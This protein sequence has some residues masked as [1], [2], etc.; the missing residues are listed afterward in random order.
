MNVA[1][2]FQKIWIFF[3]DDRFVSVLE[4]VTT[5]FVA[6]IKGDSVPSHETAHHL[7]ERDRPGA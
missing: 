5:T 3:A 1:D 4:K 6:F 7:A 2:E